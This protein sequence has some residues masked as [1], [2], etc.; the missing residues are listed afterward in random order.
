MRGMKTTLNWARA[1]TRPIL[2]I[3]G[4]TE[5]PFPVIEVDFSKQEG[6]ED[7]EKITSLQA[8]HR[9]ADALLRD[10]LLGGMP[11]RHSAVG[12]EVTDARPKIGRAHV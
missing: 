3:P 9:V 7:L 6:L 5:L 11:F 10:S 2:M 1:T 8:P 4:P 12:K